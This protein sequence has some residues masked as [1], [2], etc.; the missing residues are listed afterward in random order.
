MPWILRGSAT[1]SGRS[2]ASLTLPVNTMSSVHR[3][4]LG[5]RNHSPSDNN[6]KTMKTKKLKAIVADKEKDKDNAQTKSV[7]KEPTVFQHLLV[8]AVSGGL[9]RTVVAPL[10]RVK[11]EY[12]L[13]SSKVAAEGGMIGTLR[14]IV[15]NEGAVGLFRGN[16]LNVCR[17]APTKAVELYCF[18][19]YKE[20]VIAKKQSEA[21]A[22]HHHPK[23]LELDGRERLIGGSVSSMAGT[24]LTH[25]VDTLRS[26][27]TSSGIKMGDA[28]RGLVQN[29]GIGA[30]WKGLGANMVRVAPYGAVNFF[31]YDWCRT[32]YR[33][34]CLA[35]G[36]RM[37]AGPTLFF[38]GLAGA[39]AQTVVYPLEM[40]QRRIQVSGMA[41]ALQAGVRT[42]AV[43]QYK[44]MFHGIYV[45]AKTEGFAALYG[46]LLPNYVKIFPAA[47]VSFYVYEV[48]KANLGI[49]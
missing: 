29:E 3:S 37:K 45:V 20:W 39:A 6:A 1:T 14:R 13:D 17:I 25:P 4:S 15:S 10:E 16:M 46:G 12:M 32:M 30:L 21:G 33:K 8:G 48:M 36:E 5:T 19:K 27:V 49:A 28:W 23:A 44:N 47:A 9:S 42:K 41:S 11:I 34:R 31:V 38:G 2:I 24:A 26:R 18:D 43:A 35:P 22:G 40:V 7:A